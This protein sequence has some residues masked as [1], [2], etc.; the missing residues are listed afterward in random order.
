MTLLRPYES[1]DSSLS[2]RVHIK[3]RKTKRISGAILGELPPK[4]EDVPGIQSASPRKF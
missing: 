4:E 2:L 3:M 1:S